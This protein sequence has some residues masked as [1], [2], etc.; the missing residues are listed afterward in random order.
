[1][2]NNIDNI[3][4]SE[5]DIMAELK[6]KMSDEEK[7]IHKGHRQRVYDA[8]EKDPLLETFSEVETL[9]YL[10]FAMLPQKDTNK[11][12]HFLLRRFGSLVGIFSSSVKE[13]MQKGGVSRRIAL[14]LRSV[15]VIARKSQLLRVK[16]KSIKDVNSALEYLKLH[17]DYYYTEVMYVMCLDIK[18][19]LLGVDCVTA[20]GTPTSNTISI[21]AIMESVLHHHASKVI[22]AHNHPTGIV[23]PS[24]EDLNTTN[25]IV[26]S[27]AALD[28][29]L[30]DHLIFT[31]D[32][33][34]LSFFNSGLMHMIYKNFDEAR[35]TQ[36]F[37]Q[38]LKEEDHKLS[39]GIEYVFDIETA[40][41]VKKSEFDSLVKHRNEN[42]L[43]RE[44]GL[45]ELKLKLKADNEDNVNEDDVK[46]DTPKDE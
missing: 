31:G 11:L 25:L 14:F 3:E 33:Q 40:T 7:N 44:E 19:R 35:G 41:V 29:V 18:N 36:L 27:L 26:D 32:S 42:N 6:R 21:P 4:I 28:I 2:S 43:K 46:D 34:Y 37:T 23:R 13:L 17:F 9:E 12:A 39:S 24:I 20:K 8:I 1:M 15:P 30:L 38:L 10:L 22:L 16:E 5:K 45:L